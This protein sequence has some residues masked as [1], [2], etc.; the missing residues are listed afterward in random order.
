MNYGE[1]T[2]C[3]AGTIAALYGMMY[4]RSVF[5]E[6][7]TKPI[8]NKLVTISI[9][10][11]LMYGKIP[12]TVEELTE[13]VTV[14]YEKA[15]KEFGLAEWSGD[16]EDFYAKPYFR[17]IYRE[18]NVVRFE[19]PGLNI[20]LDYCGDPV[21][22]RGE[23]KKIKF[24]LSNKSKYVTSDRVNV[25]LYAREG[26]EILPQK[27]QNIFLSMAS[28]TII[29]GRLICWEAFIMPCQ[30]DRTEKRQPGIFKSFVLLRTVISRLKMTM[31]VLFGRNQLYRVS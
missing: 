22:R 11:F 29:F 14:L 5:D 25:Y 16:V 26:C 15:Q 1:D 21:I 12:K 28:V 13:R 4:G 2:D 8:G 20:R 10:P 24:I 30:I 18:M 19:F 3:T 31:S 17:N 6:K 23:P 7:W 27:E 9:D